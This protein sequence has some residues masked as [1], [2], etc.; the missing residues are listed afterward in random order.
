MTKHILVVTFLA[1]CSHSFLFSQDG[2]FVETRDL[3]LWSSAKAK[4]KTENKWEFGL[5][6]HF[7]FRND[8]SI[9]DQYFTELELKYEGWDN[10]RI[11]G[12]YRFIRDNDLNG[13]IKGFE[14]HGRIHL[15]LSYKH[16][17]NRW[18]LAYRFRYQSKNEFSISKEEGD[19]P[20]RNL[21]F[22]AAA[23]YNIKKW[24]L[25][26]KFS[27]EIFRHYEHGEQN[28]FNKFR[29]TAGTEYRIKKV[30]ELQFF[31]R[32]EKE[33]NSSYPKTTNILGFAFTYTF[34]KREI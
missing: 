31:Y 6:Q 8:A 23:G 25:D 14:N 1:V 30:G 9:T 28:G 18:D 15:N 22:K 16:E 19:F 13:E 12:G 2:V 24:K 27:A 4:Y 34:K 32:M 26:P 17:V 3:E 20:N 10:W 33:L 7:R 11:G 29:L 21:R 5:S